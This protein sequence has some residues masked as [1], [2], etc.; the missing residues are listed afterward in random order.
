MARRNALALAA[1]TILVWPSCADAQIAEIA[2]AQAADPLSSYIKAAGWISTGKGPQ[3]VEL[4]LDQKNAGLRVRTATNQTPQ[5]QLLSSP[6]DV[7]KVLADKRMEFLWQPLIEWSGP[8]LETMR[9][10]R[11]A[12]LRAAV[13]AGDAVL[14]P[15]TTGESTVRP[16]TRALIQL[17][18]FLIDVGQSAEAERLLQKQLS[19]MKVRTDGSWSAIEWFSIGSWIA[20]ARLAREDVAGAIAQYT[21]L[22]HALGKSPYAENATINLASLLVQNGRYADGLAAIDPLWVRWSRETREYKIGGSDRQFAWIR[23]CAL[24]GLGR[25]AEA[26]AAFQPVLQADDTKDPHY[27][28]ESDSALK[29]RGL[30][31]RKDV[32]AVERLMA[33]ELQNSRSPSGLLSLQPNL[34]PRRDAEL[35]AK[36][37]SDPSLIKLSSERMRILPPELTPALNGW[38]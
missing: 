22:E 13:A 18:S 16:K 36:I 2:K 14:P 17:A 28:V 31:C 15:L 26:D 37:R 19:S 10:R 6:S 25:H 5:I 27:V 23:A 29:L 8:T 11:L 4:I 12:D 7:L 1:I 24:E 21:L 30:V 3:F 38:R 35:W 33:D 34:L 9:D 20:S 32:A